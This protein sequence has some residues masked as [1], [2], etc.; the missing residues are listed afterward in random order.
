MCGIMGFTSKDN[1]VEA[2]LGGLSKLEYRGY[3]S[4]GLGCFKDG[5]LHSIKEKGKLHCLKEKIETMG[6]IISSCAIGHTRWATHGEPSEVNAHPHGTENVLIVHNGIIENSERIKEMLRDNGYDFTS[7]TD[8][9]AAAKLIDFCFASSKDPI[10]AIRQS[11]DLI[12]GA[13]AIAAIFKGFDDRI[14]AF[15]K[16]N[17][18][19][20]AKNEYSTF[21]ASDVLAITDYT[22]EYY[23]ISEGEI[24]I[25]SPK[26]IEFLGADDKK[27]E[28]TARFVEKAEKDFET[29]N[30]EHF[31]LKEISEEHEAVRRTVESSVSEEG[32]KLGNLTEDVV[33]KA[34]MVHV[35]ACGTAYHAGL[36]GKRFIENLSQIPVRVYYASEFRYT[37]PI[38]KKNDLVIAVSQSGETAD[39]LGAMR[40]AKKLGVRT[41]AIVNEDNSALRRESDCAFVTKAGREVSVASTKAYHV[42]LA[43][44]MLVALKF[45]LVK[46]TI[47]YSEADRLFH[48]LLNDVP[49]K[50]KNASEQKSRCEELAKKYMNSKNMFFIGRGVDVAQSREAALKMKEISYIHCNAF[51]AGELK[52]GSIALV[53]EGTP[54]VAIVTQ[55]ATFDKMISNIREVK[56]RGASVILIVSEN[57]QV[58]HGIANDVIYLPETAE[59]IFM[60]FVCATV[61]QLLAYYTSVNLGHDVDKPRN[62]AKSVTVE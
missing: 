25:L 57:M 26:A 48:I 44:F 45:A 50:I 3:D 15:R 61:T 14:Y 47:L 12:G 59:E 22:H 29:E 9:E 4:A 46:K 24:A 20:C 30:F 31:M 49:D 62:L 38:L 51:A 34:E 37:S 11:L 36:V 7:G 10:R 33:K 16:D 40:H 21:L 55:K 28:K 5:K 1:A 13:Y 58:P 53:E 54:I 56:A 41:F 23:E 42:Q 52:H 6:G 35:V 27:T 18:L 17:S 2:V 43:A 19:V 8:T 39:T 60:P 32:I